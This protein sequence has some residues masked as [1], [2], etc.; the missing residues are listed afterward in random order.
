MLRLA[1]LALLCCSA[2]APLPPLP[3][4]PGLTLAFEDDFAGPSLDLGLWQRKDSYVQTPWDTVCYNPSSS[5]PNAYTENGNLILLLH[6]QPCTCNGLP[7]QYSSGFLRA[8]PAVTD[9]LAQV[10]LMLPPPTMRVWPAAWLLS[11]QSHYDQ[12]LCWPMAPEIDILE[13]AGGFTGAPGG[14]GSNAMCA[15]YHWGTQCWVDLGGAL[16]GCLVS[17][18]DFSSSFRTYEVRWTSSSIAWSYEGAEFF[19]MD[20]D[21]HPEMRLPVGDS[22]QFTLS[23]ALAWWIPPSSAPAVLDHG[24]THSKMYVDWVRVWTA[25]A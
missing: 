15:S 18:S 21:S 8:S 22:M 1:L 2:R 7:F 17:S 14:L 11:S 9:G 4:L 20:A 13:V 12:H 24:D 16:T 5:A 23:L 10:R 3:S 25:A 6:R 19:R